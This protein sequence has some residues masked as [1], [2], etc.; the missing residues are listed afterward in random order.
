MALVRVV[1]TQT[2]FYSQESG[3][4]RSSAVTTETNPV[5]AA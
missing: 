2:A 1:D 5:S 4:D 3:V